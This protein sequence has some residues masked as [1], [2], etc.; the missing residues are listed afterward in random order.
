[1]NSPIR[2][3]LHDV[4]V[5]FGADDAD[6][7]AGADPVRVGYDVDALVAEA[8]GA[9]GPQVGQRDADA[10]ISSVRTAAER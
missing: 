1:M 7:R 3:L 6:R 5:A 2:R 4:A 9:R 10:P 8:A